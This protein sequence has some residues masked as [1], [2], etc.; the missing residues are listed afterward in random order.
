V[1]SSTAHNTLATAPAA[2]ADVPH[3][4]PPLPTEGAVIRLLEA[5]APAAGEP[6]SPALIS[7]SELVLR[8]EALAEARRM[9][10][11]IAGALELLSNSDRLAPGEPE[12]VRICE[13]AA[14]FTDISDFAAYGARRVKQAADA[15]RLAAEPDRI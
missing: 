4:M 2:A 12:H 8:A 15:I 13:I 3:V 10:D 11:G 9:A 1:R 5:A 6:K 7:E 14:L